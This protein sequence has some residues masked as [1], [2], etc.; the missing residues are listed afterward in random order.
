MSTTYT[1]STTSATSN[2]RR[3]GYIPPS[4][5]VH[6]PIEPFCALARAPSQVFIVLEGDVSPVAGGEAPCAVWGASPLIFVPC[7]GIGLSARH[8]EESRTRN[9]S[10]TVRRLGEGA[11]WRARAGE[12]EGGR[13]EAGGGCCNSTINLLNEP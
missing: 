6:V 2:E 9:V 3:P 8:G 11:R 1:T 10:Q 4:P 12:V 5:Q 7:R 13:D